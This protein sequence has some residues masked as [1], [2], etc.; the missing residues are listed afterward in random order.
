MKRIFIA[1]FLISLIAGQEI[2]VLDTKV[3]EKEIVEEEDPVLKEPITITTIIVTAVIGTTVTYILNKV[4]DKI[5]FHLTNSH[6]IDTYNENGKGRWLSNIKDGYVMS[7]YYHE[8]K[9][10]TATCQGGVLG[11]GQIRAEAGPKQWAIAL[12]KAGISGRKTF[13]NVLS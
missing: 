6:V 13:W 7:A 4:Y 9:R 10:H 2:Q 12:C 3:K 11:G 5:Y 8:T 1:L